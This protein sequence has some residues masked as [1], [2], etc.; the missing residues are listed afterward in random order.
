MLQILD[1]RPEPFLKLVCPSMRAR[2]SRDKHGR[3]VE[4]NS[5]CFVLRELEC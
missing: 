3:T 1:S 4:S 5:H 2:D